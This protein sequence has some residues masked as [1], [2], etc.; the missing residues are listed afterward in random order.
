M[1]HI[2]GVSL[3]YGLE[4]IDCRLPSRRLIGIIGAN[5]AGKSSLLKTIAGLKTPLHGEVYLQGECLADMPY[6]KRGQSLAY[7]GQETPTHWQLSVHD[8]LRLGCLP[9]L[10]PV[11]QQIKIQQLAQQFELNAL[12][13]RF[14]HTLSGGERARVHL[15]RCL[16]KEA[17]VLLADEPIAVL[18]PYYQI[19]IME[20]LKHLSRQKT[21][22]VVLHQLSLA[23]QYCDEL[24]LL[25]QGRLLDSGPTEQVIVTENLTK[26]FSISAT[27]DRQKKIIHTIRQ[28]PT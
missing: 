7:M 8:I 22:V 17:P 24:L 15:A 9:S 28:L 12:L 10:S 13:H 23:Y 20:K 21:C 2:K 26:A 16:M 25:H 1:I 5:G 3:A 19:D 18:D 6:A 14:M 11:D 27:I 4:Y